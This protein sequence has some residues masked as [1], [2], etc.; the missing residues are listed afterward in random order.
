MSARSP[1]SLDE[2]TKRLAE[3]LRS[4][5]EADLDAV[6]FTLQIGRRA[7]EHRRAVVCTDV[8]DAI[9]V[10][11]SKD[12]TRATAIV[13][14][15]HAAPVV[16]MFPGQGS[17]YLDM[18]AGLY[19]T[20]TKFREDVNLCAEILKPH[21]QTD[22]CAAL[23]SSEKP[24]SKELRDT[25]IVQPALF[26]IEYALARLWMR[27]GVQPMAMI[28]HSVGEFVAACLA[29]VFS[30]E[31]ALAIIA[32]RAR[33]MS[34]LPPGAMLSVRL[35]EE[36]VGPLLNGELSLAAAN[37]PRLSVVSGSSM[38][39]DTFERKMSQ[40]GV[41]VRR[42]A[43]SHAFHSRMMDPILEPFTEYVTKFRLNVPT[44]PYVSCV[45]GTWITADEATDPVYWA[46]HFREPV[47]FSKGIQA[48]QSISENVLLEVGP[49]RVL[50]TLA[51]QHQGSVPVKAAISLPDSAEENADLPTL[52]SA[53]SILWL[54]GVPL[55]WKEMHG[56]DVHRCSLP[57]YPFE[58]QR[59][60]I[61]PPPPSTALPEHS[62]G[63]KTPLTETSERKS[64]PEM[65]SAKPSPGTANAPPRVE[66]LR[67]AVIGIFQDLSGLSLAECDPSATFLEMGLDSL[68]LTQVSQALQAK[69]GLRVTFRQLLDHFSTVDA[70]ASHLDAELPAEKFAAEVAVPQPVSESLPP[71]GP[72]TVEAVVRE[73]LQVMTQLMQKQ[74][75]A[76]RGAG[77]A[78]SVPPAN[79]VFAPPPGAGAVKPTAAQEFKPFGPYKPVQRGPVGG[80]TER[81]RRH[82]DDLIRRYTAHTAKSKEATQG[83]RRVLADPRVA[84]GFRSQWKEMVYPLVTVRSQGCRL[85]DV[86]GNEYIDLLNGFGPILFGHGPT[87]ITEAIAA[88]LK[89]GFEIGPQTPLAGEVAALDLRTHRQRARDLLQHRLR[90]RHGGAASC[91]HRDGA[92]ED[93]PVRRRLPRNFR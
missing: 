8:A 9:R 25:G 64:L 44:I 88:Q 6:A 70:L 92:H 2:G 49:G 75:E 47:R 65:T 66:R 67:T 18:G 30:L 7:F 52:L 27:W 73:Q 61:D 79:V 84:A 21:L 41:A 19:R 74:L 15:G 16:L 80:F 55:N 43:T 63:V 45:T 26:I 57:T 50:S 29:G 91:P 12:Q 24:L 93:R 34:E 56:P 46:R 22:L 11:E 69:F 31:D 4:R 35:S 60:W 32:T 81:Q 68:F 42:L 72:T 48:I 85:C 39:I 1:K 40:G 62:T 28:G 90:G 77:S 82:L 89:E 20:D 33:M 83:R 78:T 87:F 53:A 38:A 23:Y 14:Q 71:V 76:L 59:Y 10:L 3:H 36:E 17:Q 37:A 54:N 5:P 58:R 86:D 51:R 13:R